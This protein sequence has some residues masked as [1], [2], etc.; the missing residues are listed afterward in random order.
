MFAYCDTCG[1]DTG[2]HNSRDK[3]YDQI[4]EDGGNV[5]RAEPITIDG[6]A[7]PRLEIACPNGHN[8]IRID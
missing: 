1:Y 2:D 7:Y 3:I 5:E 4:E 8:S 6:E